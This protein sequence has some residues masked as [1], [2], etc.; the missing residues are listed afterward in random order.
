MAP[1]IQARCAFQPAQL[2][3]RARRRV[4]RPRSYCQPSLLD[5]CLTLR[6]RL[7]PPTLPLLGLALRKMLVSQAAP[8]EAKLPSGPEPVS[9]EVEYVSSEELQPL[10]DPQP[11][12]QA[13]V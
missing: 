3:W 6:L 13:R 5:A 9:V 11:A 7:M 10:E 12:G 8:S 1:K 4:P 2:I